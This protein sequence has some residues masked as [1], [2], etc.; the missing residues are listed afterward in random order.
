[1]KKRLSIT[2]GTLL[3]L[4]IFSLMAFFIKGKGP[5]TLILTLLSITTFLFGVIGAYFM[6]DAHSRL[7]QIREILRKNDSNY[8]NIY[9]LSEVFG[10]KT[11]KEV[12]RYI[13]KYLTSTIDYYLWDYHKA[14]KDFLKL[15]DYIKKIRPSNAAQER[16]Y[17][18]ILGIT[19]EAN[20]N[21]KTVEYLVRDEMWRF[22]WGLS[23]VCGLS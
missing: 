16:V 8:I 15:Y 7:S 19:N 18:Q 13:D 3:A 17:G 6:Q 10:K 20:T 21:R 23:S 9:R 1:M 4:I 2:E 5:E 22:N 12:Q 11:Q 14:G